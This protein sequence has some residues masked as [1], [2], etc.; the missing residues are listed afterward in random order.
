M[1]GYTDLMAVLEIWAFKMYSVSTK[2]IVFYFPL[3]SSNYFSH[4]S[5]VILYVASPLSL[6]LTSAYC[7]QDCVSE[8]MRHARQSNIPIVIDGVCML[9]FRHCIL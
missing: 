4:W 7:Y 9:R 6:I 3:L 1:K 2:L 8:I 5:S